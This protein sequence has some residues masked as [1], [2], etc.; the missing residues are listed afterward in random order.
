MVKNQ[1]VLVASDCSS[2]LAILLKL[3]FNLSEFTIVAASRESDVLSMVDTLQPSLILSYFRR[4]KAILDVLHRR[5]AQ[6]HVPI[7]ILIR[8]FE[9]INLPKLQT[10]PVLVQSY[11]FAVKGDYLRTNV[12]NLLRWYHPK[13][14]KSDATPRT[15]FDKNLARYSLEIDQKT[16]MLHQ[17]RGQIKKLYPNV[18]HP[19]RIKLMSLVNSIKVG[20]TDRRH[21][22]D[23]QL[24]FENINPE[25]IQKLSK[26]FPCLTTKDLKYCCYLKMNMSNEDIRHVLGISQDSVRMHKYRLKKKMTLSKKEDLRKY[27]TAFSDF[28]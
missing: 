2:S 9:N 15:G 28:Q 8:N 3:L 6:C 13:A 12:L 22:E 20:P 27:L 26:K 10:A 1:C 16:T 11:D 21:W 14:K 17:I 19:T 24:Y 25:F 5:N 23:F 18:D 7:I 4:P